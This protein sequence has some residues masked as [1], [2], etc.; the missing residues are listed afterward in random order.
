MNG[1][2]DVRREWAR[3]IP[4]ASRSKSVCSPIDSATPHE[5]FP[6]GSQARD[7]RT[8]RGCPVAYSVSPNV[9]VMELKVFTEIDRRRANQSL[10]CLDDGPDAHKIV[11]KR[12]TWQ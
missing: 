2:R 12:K 11:R 5:T 7:V 3:D 8:K 10:T 9:R 1:V 4:I 6:R